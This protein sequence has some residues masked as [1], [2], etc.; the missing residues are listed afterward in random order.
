MLEPNFQGLFSFALF[1]LRCHPLRRLSLSFLSFLFALSFFFGCLS[2]YLFIFPSPSLLF[3]QFVL[4]A[5]FSS[6]SCIVFIIFELPSLPPSV[7]CCPYLLLSLS[8]ALVLVQALRLKPTR[9]LPFKCPPFPAGLSLANLCERVLW[10]PPKDRQERRQPTAHDIASAPLLPPW[11]P[12]GSGA[13][14]PKGSGGRVG[15][16]PERC[17]D[18]E[19]NNNKKAVV[20]GEARRRKEQESAQIHQQTLFFNSSAIYQ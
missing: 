2:F 19:Q 17:G 5:L 13:V 3:S 11:Q 20:D 18:R 12:H 14:T 10:N 9:W 1:L 16:R 8:I 4:A 7:L 15:E 6:S